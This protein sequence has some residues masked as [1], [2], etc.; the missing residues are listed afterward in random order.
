MRLSEVFSD[1]DVDE[2]KEKISPDN[3][4]VNQLKDKIKEKRRAIASSKTSAV[5]GVAASGFTFGLSLWGTAYEGRSLG[6][7][8]Q[9][10]GLLEAE[11]E[12]RG[13]EKLPDNFSDKF[14]PVFKTAL[15]G[16]KACEWDAAKAVV[17]EVRR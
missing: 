4:T 10:L 8:R 14:V 6:V 7:D 13:Y 11:W 12:G 16:L 9:K 2:Y 1:F 17:N 5:A 15:L 3:M